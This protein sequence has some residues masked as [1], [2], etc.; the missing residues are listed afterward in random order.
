[1]LSKEFENLIKAVQSSSDNLLKYFRKPIPLKVKSSNVDYQTKADI[2]T[3]KSIIKA[4]EKIFPDYNISGEEHGEK[5]KNSPYTFIIDPL[6]G[7]NNFVLGIPVFVTNVALMKN[8]EVI[9]GIVH[10][11]ITEDTY[12]AVKGKGAFLNGKQIFVKKQSSAE[13]ITVSYYCDYTTPKARIARFKSYLIIPRIKRLLDL[14]SPGYCF[15]SLAAGKV[16]AI[17]VDGAELY[18]FAAGKLIAM[19]AGAKVTNFSGGRIDSDSENKFVI[20][21]GNQTHHFLISQVT[22]KFIDP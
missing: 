2:E 14:W 7:T 11:P 18:D 21:N 1:M 10:H 3:E 8:G 9:F 6:D 16:D 12:Y 4:I 22:Q 20:S 13:N 17:I 5:Y 15:C 19:E